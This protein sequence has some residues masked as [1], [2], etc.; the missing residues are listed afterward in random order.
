MVFS[1]MFADSA[2]GNWKLSGLRV[3]YY[4]IARADASVIVTDV[5]GFGLGLSLAEIPAGLMFNHTPNGPFTDAMLQGAGVN[6]NVNLYPDGTGVI[7]EGSYYPDV[8]IGY[9]ADG[10]PDCISTGQI[11]P[12]TDSFNWNAPGNE[13]TFPYVNIL[14]TPSYN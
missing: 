7:G 9:D 1:M 14:G 11:Y 8:D 12:I 10:N 13:L 5:Y 2:V 3:D 6:L 4:D